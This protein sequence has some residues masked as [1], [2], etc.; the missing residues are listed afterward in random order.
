[1]LQ[2]AAAGLVWGLG[3]GRAAKATDCERSSWAA[4]MKQGRCVRVCV[5]A[6]VRVCLRRA[7][8]RQQWY[9]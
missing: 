8:L 2:K 4:Y 1:M 9:A 6:C 5:C 7:A 3:V